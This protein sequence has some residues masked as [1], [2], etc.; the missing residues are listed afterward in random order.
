MI[1]PRVPAPPASLLAP[2]RAID[3]GA[4][5][6][7]FTSDEPSRDR[8]NDSK[9]RPPS[10]ELTETSASMVKGIEARTLEEAEAEADRDAF[11]F[12][13]PPS[14]GFEVD[15]VTLEHC[16][17]IRAALAMPGSDRAAVLAKNDLDDATWS[18]VEK[19]HMARIDLETSKGVMDL[20]SR[21]DASYVAAQDKLR[22][23]IGVKEFAR[24]VVAREDGSLAEAMAELGIPRSEL[25]RLDRVWTLRRAAYPGVEKALQATLAATRETK[26]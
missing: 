18:R 12:P 5:K 23:P 13:L 22:R 3:H 2:P 20:L 10:D 14:D 25:M 26:R 15:G 7:D 6:D 1:A 19:A 24:I 17:A 8:T 9:P 4:D 16:A 21:Y 11:E